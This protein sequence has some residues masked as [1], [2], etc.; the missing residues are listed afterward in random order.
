MAI[1]FENNLAAKLG[2]AAG[3][4][5][6]SALQ[7]GL[8]LLQQHRMNQLTSKAQQEQQR[9]QQSNVAGSLSKFNVS[10]DIAQAIAAL[11]PKMQEAALQN[12]PILQRLSQP[13]Q[14]GQEPMGVQQSIQQLQQQPAESEFAG[15]FTSPHERREEEKLGLKRQQVGQQAAK[16]TRKFSE[17]YREKASASESNIRDYDLLSHIAKKG[18]LRA[19]NSAQLLDKLGLQ[20]FNRNFNT[21]LAD[22]LIARLAQNARGAFGSGSRI[23]NYLEQ[24][25]QRSLPTLWN[26]PEGIIAISEINKRAD[27]LNIVKDNLRKK[28]VNEWKGNIPFNADDI[29]DDLAKPEQQKLEKEALDIANNATQVASKV[30]DELP[31]ASKFSGKRIRDKDSGKVLKSNGKEWVEEK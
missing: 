23:T 15:L 19:G 9:Q 16:D 17:P 7:S 25:F 3:K 22:K 24:V 1:E 10:P 18:D 29:I 30:F 11:P 31:D 20:G 4:G 12:L 21:Q 6:S 5:V 28:L 8:D 2:G 13:Q 26:T 27:Q 14:Q